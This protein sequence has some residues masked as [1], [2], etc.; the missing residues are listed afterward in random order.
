M[1]KSVINWV[2]QENLTAEK[3]FAEVKAAC[4]HLNLGF[5]PIE[6]IPFADTL[7]DFEINHLNIYFGSSNLTELLHRDPEIKSGIWYDP[8]LFTMANYLKAWG[9]R[10]LNSDSQIIPFSEVSHLSFKDNQ[11]LFIRPNADDKT[12]AGNVM[13]FSQIKEWRHRL[14]DVS[15][16]RLNAD[17]KILIGEPYRIRTEWRLW[18]VQGKMVAASQ[19]RRDFK[20]SEKEGCPERVKAFAEDSCAEYLLDDVFVMDVCE[21]GDELYMVECNCMNSAGYYKADLVALIKSV[22]SYVEA[23]LA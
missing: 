14:D 10:M 18:L 20:L 15:N 9:P 11:N 17:T 13:T 2:V 19:Y 7:P 4:K 12:F 23:S 5:T 22:S 21:T 8:G 3:D 6:L 16:E 1:T